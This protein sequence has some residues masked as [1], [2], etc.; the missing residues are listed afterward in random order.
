MLASPDWV[1]EITVAG[2]PYRRALIANGQA[3]DLSDQTLSYLAGFGA[4][5][6]CAVSLSQRVAVQVALG[7][8]LTG[9]DVA[10]L[11]LTDSQAH[12]TLVARA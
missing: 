9:D 5:V 12:P 6:Q 2:E 10:S 7:P 4:R 1:R 8:E 3:S 11:S